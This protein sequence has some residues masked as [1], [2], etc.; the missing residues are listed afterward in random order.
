MG[1]EFTTKME[2]KGLEDLDV[3]RKATSESQWYQPDS[4]FKKTK[5]NKTQFSEYKY[6]WSTFP[7]DDER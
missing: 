2:P 1:P 5:Q 7:S 4:G 6:L 3:P